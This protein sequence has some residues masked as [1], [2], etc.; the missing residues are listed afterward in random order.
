MIRRI[1]N[2]ELP[3]RKSLFLWG[4]RKTGKSTFLKDKYPNSRWIDLLKGDVFLQYLRRPDSLRAEIISI[5]DDDLFP[6]IIDEVQKVPMLLD[7]VH[8]LL[9][10]V[11]GCSFILCGSS[12]RKLKESGANLLGGRAWR[13]IFLPLCFPELPHFDLLK[14]L[15][16]GL[17]PE[18]YLEEEDAIRSLDSYIA[19]YLIPEIQWESRIRNLVAFSKFLEVISFSNGEL[20]NVSHIARE[21]GVSVKTVQSY[22]DILVDM[23][24]GYV[25]MPYTKT[26]SRQLIVGHPKFYFFDPGVVRILKGTPRFSVL[27]GPEAG[28]AFEHYVFLE[29]MAFKEINRLRFDIKFWRSRSG[30]EVDFILNHGEIAIECKVQGSLE[31]RDL[32]GLSQFTKEHKPKKSII[33]CQAPQK[34]QMNVEENSIEIYPLELFLKDLWDGKI[35]PLLQKS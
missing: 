25:I 9:E 22:I 33:V 12:L 21:S 1:L 13:Q 20:I 16:D 24:L 4:A 32:S 18:H 15:N 5:K 8:W 26:V 14:I 7:E 30:L 2:L 29:L 3:K 27:K 34:R 28:H 17:L 6:V 10:N 19:D 11:P 31:K 35:I 23:L